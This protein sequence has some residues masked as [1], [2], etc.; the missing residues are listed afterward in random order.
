[1]NSSMTI[2]THFLKK[3]N[4]LLEITQ[5]GVENTTAKTEMPFFMSVVSLPLGNCIAFWLLHLKKDIV[6]LKRSTGEETNRIT[7]SE[8]VSYE[9]RLEKSR[10][11][12]LRKAMTKAGGHT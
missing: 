3:A 12:Q 8:H 11:C 5:K 10:T 4:S 1:M 7:G 2:S 9:E 6:E